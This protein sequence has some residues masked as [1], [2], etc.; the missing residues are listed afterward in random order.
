ML[1]EAINSLYKKYRLSKYRSLFSRIKERSGS[2]SATEAFCVDIINLLDKPTMKQF[3]DFIGV[4]QSNATYKVNSLIQKGYIT[5]EVGADD[6]REFRLTTTDKFH[7]YFDSEE[8]AV[9][10][11]LSILQDKY[12]D[13]QLRLFNEMLDV[14]NEHSEKW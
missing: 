3:S 14:L 10:E 1:I 6:R 4:S 12:S 2:L 9:S 7:G 8:D 13:D 5:K 11:A